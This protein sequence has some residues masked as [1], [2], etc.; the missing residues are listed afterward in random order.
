M[1]F[2]HSCFN[3]HTPPLTPQPSLLAPCNCPQDLLCS[4][5]EIFH[6]ISSLDPSKST[7]PDGISARMLKATAVSVIPSI[8]KLFNLSLASGTSPD[9]WKLARIVPIPKA[10]D[11][12]SPTNYRPVSIL[13]IV[14]KL[15]ERHIHQLIFQY[16]C[17]N[18]P[19]SERQWGFLPGR[20]ASSALLSVTHD[21]FNHLE[22]GNEVCSVFFDLKKAFDSVPHCLLLHKLSEICIDPFIIQWVHSYLTNRSQLVVVGGEQ[23]SVLPVLSGVPQGSVLGPLLFLIYI[24]EVVFQVSP[25]STMSLFADDMALYRPISSATDYSILQCDISAIATWIKNNCLSLQPS[26]C[27]YMLISRK[28]VSPYHL[29]LQ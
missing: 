3:N 9:S 7:G 27:C 14:S 10:S 15:L 25:G 24:N 19:I 16:L 6:L 1:N 17:V 21:W 4:E 29:L 23:S 8:T 18:Y 26:K 12:S 13:S 20:S 5:D 22:K 11:P 28:K 2:F